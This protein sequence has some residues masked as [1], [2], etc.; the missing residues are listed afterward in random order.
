MFGRRKDPIFGGAPNLAW[1][2][3]D[4]DVRAM[5]ARHEELQG[6]AARNIVVAVLLI[7]ATISVEI[8]SYQ[9]E[10]HFTLYDVLRAVLFLLLLVSIASN[11]Y[12]Y[13]THR[14]MIRFF[15]EGRSR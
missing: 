11:S 4:N 9:I 8:R 12:A 10:H 3:H 7:A 6:R 5:R 14:N 13:V 1:F 15:K 2:M